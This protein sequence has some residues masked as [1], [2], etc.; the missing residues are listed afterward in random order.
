VKQAALD[1]AIPVSENVA[2]VTGVGAE[3]GV[4]VAFGRLVRPEVLDALAMVNIHFSLLPRWRGAAPVER[5]LLEGDV[6]TGVSIMALD[7]GLDTGPVYARAS[8]RI[9]ADETAAELARRLG[10]LGSGLLLSLLDGGVA[11]L[12]RPEP[13]VGEA[14]YAA[15]L[16]PDDLRLHWSAG[17][18]HCHR[19]VRVG[20][21]WTT[22]RGGRLVVR[23]ARVAPATAVPPG[24]APPRPG[25]LLDGR[26]AT[27]D[28]DLV[29]V[30]VQAA[31]RAVQPYAEWARGTRPAPGEV[32]GELAE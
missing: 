15:K 28:G 12:P 23:V 30:D 14:T 10:E 3:L 13:Q 19:T 2:D 27:S 25:T 22:F 26:V 29:L 5:A 4:I 18:L 16:A 20:R 6:E 1:L 17:A 11:G 7:A 9:G 31:G 32:L 21:A 8:T 24:A